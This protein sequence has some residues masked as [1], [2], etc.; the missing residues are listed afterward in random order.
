MNATEGG[1]PFSPEQEARIAAIAEE[2]FEPLGE[3]VD[4]ILALLR[5]M[6]EDG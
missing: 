2:A 1:T 3:R 5:V 4:Q 6:R